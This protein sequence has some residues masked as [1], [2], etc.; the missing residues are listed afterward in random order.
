[1]F[2]L[3][4]IV[5]FIMA[6]FL[7][8]KMFIGFRPGS[9]KVNTDVSRFRA[10]AEKWKDALVPWTH[11]EITLFSWNEINKVKKRGFGRTFEAVIE[12]IYHEPMLY[13][14]YKEYPS[15]RKNAIIFAQSHQYEF[16]FRIR[17]KGV[18]VFINE[19]FT[20]TIGDDGS[21][22][23][24]GERQ[25]LGKVD[26]YDAT[27][28]TVTIGDQVA[29]SITLPLLDSSVNQRVYDMDIKLDDQQKPLFMALTL[30]YVISELTKE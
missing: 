21:F 16:V 14:Y 12:S 17:K 8:N 24:E 26:R 23:H 9:K 25:L 15:S 11:E 5:V 2:S 6:V 4:S 7:M 10:H 13:Y 29:G 28:K 22:Y 20:G 30:F 18:Q 3:L 19:E 1:M 27:R